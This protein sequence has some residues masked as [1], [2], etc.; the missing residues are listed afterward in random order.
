MVAWKMIL[1]VVP[2]SQ[3][4]CSQKIQV[5]LVCELGKSLLGSMYSLLLW[6]EFCLSQLNK[7]KQKKKKKNQHVLEAKH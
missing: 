2:V 7:T 3:L 6:G 1:I 5:Q 4:K